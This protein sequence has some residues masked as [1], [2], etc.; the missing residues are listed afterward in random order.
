M[1]VQVD[2]SGKLDT[3]VTL[4]LANFSFLK[5]LSKSF[6]RV[7][8]HSLVVEYKP[9]SS[10]MNSGSVA[11]GMDWNYSTRSDAVTR[12]KALACTPSLHTPVY[13]SKAISLPTNQLMSRRQYII[14]GDQKDASPGQLLVSC[15]GDKASLYAGD[16]FIRYSVTLSGTNT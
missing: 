5:T 6:D 12:E 13:V 8:W 14:G 3:A 2:P 1:K 7:T 16:L 4:E 11:V 10:A 9:Y 15:S